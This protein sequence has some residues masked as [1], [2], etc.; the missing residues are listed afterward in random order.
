MFLLLNSLHVCCF[1]M[2][3]S[4]WSPKIISPRI[5]NLVDFAAATQS[6][7]ISAVKAE[8]RSLPRS[9]RAQR[10][11]KLYC[12]FMVIY[13]D[14]MGFNGILMGFYSD[15]MGFMGFYWILWWLKGNLMGSYGDLMGFNGSLWWLNGYLMEIMVTFHGIFHGIYWDIASNLWQFANW[16]MGDL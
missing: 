12:D 13:G 16:K 1:P 9:F 5:P 8:Q 11:A 6:F 14:L 2:T 4:Y 3:K 10:R 15:L 7:R